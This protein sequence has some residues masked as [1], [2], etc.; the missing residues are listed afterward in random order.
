MK[1]EV[2]KQEQQEQSGSERSINI[3]VRN[4]LREATGGNCGRKRS[5]SWSRQWEMLEEE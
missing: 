1:S 2:S 5:N 4:A 3:L